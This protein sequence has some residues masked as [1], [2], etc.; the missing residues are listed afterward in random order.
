MSTE[1][2]VIFDIPK[3]M[4]ERIVAYELASYLLGSQAR[5]SSNWEQLPTFLNDTWMLDSSNDYWFF[6]RREDGRG[7]LRCRYPESKEGRVIV[8][9]TT[10]FK[11]KFSLD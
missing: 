3:G 8:A 5:K 4:D 10:M 2:E 9:M 6:L 7:S 1:R 11:E